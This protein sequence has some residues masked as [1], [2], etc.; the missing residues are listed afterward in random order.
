MIFVFSC[1]KLSSMKIGSRVESEFTDFFVFSHIWMMVYFRVK[2]CPSWLEP[3][4]GA[5]NRSKGY[6][7][8]RKNTATLDST[9]DPVNINAP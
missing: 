5:R 9:N 3:P 8:N 4:A 1:T 7:G 2:V 6:C